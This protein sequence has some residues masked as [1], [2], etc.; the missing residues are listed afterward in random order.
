MHIP[1]F[2]FLLPILCLS[3]C[4]SLHQKEQFMSAAGFRTVVPSTPAQIAQLKSLPQ[5]KVLPVVKNGKTLFL[6]ADAGN[7]C[8][9]IGTQRQYQTNQQYAVQYKVQQE[10]LNAAA[11]NADGDEWGAWGGMGGPFW[12]PCFY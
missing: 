5:G 9:M 7:N 11:L 10:K 12:G 6:F 2:L 4:G 3:G 8:L 1:R